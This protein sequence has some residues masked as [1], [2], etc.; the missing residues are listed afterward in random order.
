MKGWKNL[1]GRIG[2]R[3]C[4]HAMRDAELFDADE[5]MSTLCS[6]SNIDFWTIRREIAL[7]L[8]D[9]AGNASPA[10]VDRVEERILQTGEA[11]YNRYTIEHGED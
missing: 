5:A 2:L 10:L 11:Y 1:P 8:R 9:R 7:L 6:A 3:L 4:L